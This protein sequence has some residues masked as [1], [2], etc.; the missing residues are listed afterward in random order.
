MKTRAIM[1][2]HAAMIRGEALHSSS[3][4][5]TEPF[6]E[7]YSEGDVYEVEYSYRSQTGDVENFGYGMNSN[8]SIW[9]RSKVS[10]PEF[11]HVFQESVWHDESTRSYANWLYISDRERQM[12]RPHGQ[13]IIEFWGPDTLD[14][15]VHS[16]DMIHFD[17]DAFGN[18]PVFEKKVTSCSSRWDPNNADDF[19]HFNGG[20][21]LNYTHFSFPIT[22]DSVRKYS[23]YDDLGVDQSEVNSRVTELIFMENHFFV[24]HRTLTPGSRNLSSFPIGSNGYDQTL[25]DANA[26]N[27]YE[28]PPNGALFIIGEL[29]LVGPNGDYHFNCVNGT[30]TQDFWVS[31]FNDRLTIGAS[32]D[33]VIAQ[34][35]VYSQFI[36][37][38][39]SMPS[40]ATAALGLIS[41]KHILVW[42]K[43]PS[44]IKITAGLG[45]IG[46]NIAE[47]ST[48]HRWDARCQN[49]AGLIPVNGT[50]GTISIDGIN[51]YDWS[52]EKQELLI[53]GCLIQ[54]ERGL[55]H[56]SFNGGLR[57]Y[58]SKAYRY[59]NRFINNPPPHFFEMRSIGNYYSERQDDW[60]GGYE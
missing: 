56:S 31:G 23:W 21:S 53:Y 6:S 8:Y 14:G 40:S 60:S 27:S 26:G 35:V 59:D 5:Y 28:Y 52:N 19:V 47:D 4:V 57:G 25:Y 9:G 44:F 43:A 22:A 37:G 58:I 36:D 33:I 11:N 50:N 3:Y 2:A 48:L 45:A 51:C 17:S 32:G 20:F 29:W 42:R 49:N 18:W 34:D 10:C 13:D 41:E 38:P 15:K 7:F 1:A 24:R 54:R 39:D 55:V 12:Y 46:F 16:N 30:E